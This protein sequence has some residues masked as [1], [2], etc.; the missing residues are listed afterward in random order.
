MDADQ[1]QQMVRQI[2]VDKAAMMRQHLRDYIET[3]GRVGYLRDMTAMG[4]SETMLHLILRTLGRRSGRVILTPLTYA[5][6]G[7]EFVLVGSKGGN[8][9]HP[10]WYLNLIARSEVEWQV[11]D[12]RFSGV[13]RLAEGEERDELWDYVSRYY[14]GYAAY[15]TR[16]D[17]VLPVVV[18]TATGRIEE[19]WPVPD[20]PLPGLDR[21]NVVAP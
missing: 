14:K 1:T 16:T 19:R 3:D 4:G 8:A 5:A 20:D 9:T 11:R 13:W 7:D 15:A 17:R 21:P 2:F 10:D 12:K 18:L 6:W